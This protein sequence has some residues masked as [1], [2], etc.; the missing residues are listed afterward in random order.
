MNKTST[1]GISNTFKDK[2]ENFMK[3]L[4]KARLRKP[5]TAVLTV[6]LAVLTVAL[7]GV[8]GEITCTYFGD[9]LAE[10]ACANTFSRFLMTGGLGLVMAGFV[11]AVASLPT[12]LLYRLATKI[13][14]RIL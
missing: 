11:V 14:D 1:S 2:R 4:D 3:K 8:S 10:H 7:L 9:N 13:V 12:I 5:L 6:A